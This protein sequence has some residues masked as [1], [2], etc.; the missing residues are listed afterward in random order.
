[1]TE[2]VNLHYYTMGQGF[3][4]VMIHG[5]CSDGLGFTLQTSFAY[6]YQLI[7]PDLRGHGKSPKPHA[8]CNAPLL[9]AD[10]NHLLEKM[11]IDRAILCGGSFGGMVA[12]Q[13]VLDYPQ[14]VE[15]LILS[16]TTSTFT[17]S[18]Q[19]MDMVIPMLSG[20][21]AAE[22]VRAMISSL[23][24]GGEMA[25]SPFGAMLIEASLERL[26]DL[27]PGSLLEVTKG[28]K[29]FEV[30]H[31]LSEIKVPALIIAAKR[32]MVVP[33]Q[34]S[35]EMHKQIAGSEYVVI[36]SDHGTPFFRPDEWNR[37]VRNFLKK[38]GH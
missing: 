4:L 38:M 18:T 6:R 2:T 22:M 35:E 26:V 5:W 23:A 19:F 30:T 1:M 31:R 25:K 16:D 17:A 28:M 13:F 9:A 10:V 11:G 14:K 20:P 29:D 7:L 37:T 34:Y 12:L 24:L 27:D 15:A 8:T 3:P 33:P 36:D 21:N 32:D